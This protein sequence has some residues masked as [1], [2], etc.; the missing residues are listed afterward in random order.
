MKK[1]ILALALTTLVSVSAH[2]AHHDHIHLSAKHMVEKDLNVGYVSYDLDG[3]TLD[4]FS[5]SHAKQYD[6]G[7]YLRGGLEYYSKSMMGNTLKVSNIVT[8]VGKQFTIDSDSLVYA[9]AALHFQKAKFAGFSD[10]NTE[11]EVAAGYK[12][13]LTHN[14]AG[15]IGARYMDSEAAGEVGLRYSFTEKFAVSASYLKAS[16]TDKVG[17]SLNVYF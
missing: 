13:A 7:I 16:D 14:L 5:I 3:L 17:V 4:G 1:S 2:A 15:K 10:S 12:R 8:Q 9:E 6:S 11:I